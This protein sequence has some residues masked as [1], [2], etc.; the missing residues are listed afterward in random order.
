MTH[1]CI[2]LIQLVMY[3]LYSKYP[4]IR[5][6]PGVSTR[7]KLIYSLSRPFIITNPTKKILEMLTNSE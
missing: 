4:Y 3:D 5:L 7:V 6:D 1:S 2:S